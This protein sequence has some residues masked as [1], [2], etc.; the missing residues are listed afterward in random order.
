MNVS[1]NWLHF[2]RWSPSALAFSLPP[3]PFRQLVKFIFVANEMTLSL[4]MTTAMIPVDGTEEREGVMTNFERKARS[5]AYISYGLG[6]A[7]LIGT[8]VPP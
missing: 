6:G 1:V 3:S 7:A 2:D 5:L 4:S 8:I